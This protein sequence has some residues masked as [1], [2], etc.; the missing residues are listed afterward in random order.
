MFCK[1][2]GNEIADDTVFCS[3]CGKN[4]KEG[5]DDYSFSAKNTANK[6]DTVNKQSSVSIDETINKTVDSVSNKIENTNPLCIAGLVLT[7]IMF[8]FNS[9]GV[10]GFVALVLSFL[11]YKAARKNRQKGTMIAIVCMAVAGITSLI[12]IIRFIE[13]QRYESAVYGELNGFL[14]WLGDLL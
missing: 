9:Y 12:F 6:N 7:V 14:N 11:G 13:Y 1:Y 10:V 2:C 4:V 3:K 5:N 8:F